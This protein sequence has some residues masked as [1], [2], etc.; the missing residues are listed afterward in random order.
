MV[1]RFTKIVIYDLT[2]WYIME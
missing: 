1:Q 2:K